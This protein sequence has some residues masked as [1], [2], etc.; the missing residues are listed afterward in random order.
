MASVHAESA[1]LAFIALAQLMKRA[2]AGRGMSMREGIELAQSSVDVVVQCSR[3][4][5]RRFVSEIWYDP[6]AKRRGA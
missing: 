3:A 1:D 5:H 4:R 6:G 2:D